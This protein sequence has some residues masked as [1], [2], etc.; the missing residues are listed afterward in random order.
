MVSHSLA[1]SAWRFRDTSTKTWLPAEVP[2]CVHTDLMRAGRIPDPFYG[3][4][5]LD[6]QW[7]VGAGLG[8]RIDV[9]RSGKP[10]CGRGDRSGRRRA[11]HGRHRDAERS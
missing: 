7:I 10:A 1:G 3:T 6:L 2:G 11:R 8:V 4:N 5:E 9:H